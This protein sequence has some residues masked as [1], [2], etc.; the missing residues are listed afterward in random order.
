MNFYG[1]VGAS[2]SRV[3][4]SSCGATLDSRS[5]QNCPECSGYVCPDCAKLYDGFCDACYEQSSMDFE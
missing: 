3:T 2:M 1:K 5:M 4:C